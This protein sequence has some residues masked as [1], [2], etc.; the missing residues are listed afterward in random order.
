VVVVSD[1][2]DADWWEGHVEGKPEKVGFFPASFVEMIEE[3]APSDPGSPRSSLGG[4]AIGGGVD[5]ATVTFEYEAEDETNITITLGDVVVVSDKSDAD[6]WEGHV[7]GKPE[8]V[9]FF[10]ASFVEMIEEGGGAS[11]GG[12]AREQQPVSDF[13]RE[14]ETLGPADE[15]PAASPSTPA[16]TVVDSESGPAGC[17]LLSPQ[18]PSSPSSSEDGQWVRVSVE[19][20]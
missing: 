3:G 20:S 13:E 6:W 8:K 17:Q 18:P 11:G 16:R 5:R 9:G 2:S 10:P 4:D 7:E 1:K 15:A 14:W 19:R 12:A